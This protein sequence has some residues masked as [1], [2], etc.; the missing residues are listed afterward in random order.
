MN[1]KAF[2]YDLNG[3][4]Q[5]MVNSSGTTTYSWDYENRLVSAALP[6]SGGTVYFKYDPFGRRIYKSSP[7]SASI[8][9]YDGDN[10]AEETNSTGTAVARYAQGLNI[11][12]PL[13]MLRSG[14][15][16]YYQADGLG[17]LTSLSTT[18]GAMANT[19]TYDSFGNLTASTGSVTN[20]FRYTGREWDSETNLYYYRARYYDPISG[21]FLSEDP[22]G[23][24][25]GVNF[26]LYVLGNPV[27]YIDPYGLDVT[28]TISNRTY[29]PSGNSVSGTITVTS[30]QTSITFTGPTLE[31]SHAGDDGSKPPI[32]GGTYGA[33]IRTDHDPH[34]IELKNVHGYR[35]IQI[36]NGNYPRDFKGCFGAGTSSSPDSIGGSRDA[37]R[38]INKVIDA[39]GTG[40]ITVIVNPIQNGKP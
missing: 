35:N 22:M 36:H 25:A 26:Y 8:Y 27:N 2:A 34:R 21:R 32:P 13:A 1:A 11:D 40:R 19:Y 24:G 29:S 15:T 28:I 6:N 3:N 5:T 7:S 30:D 4:T 31:T 17:S 37:M 23:F 9:A 39:D 14:A 12:E 38:Q 18:S 33:F 16:S 10:I 20:S